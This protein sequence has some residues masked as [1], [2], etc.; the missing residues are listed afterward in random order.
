M[1][2]A[3]N[4]LDKENNNSIGIQ[5]TWDKKN[6][7]SGPPQQKVIYVYTILSFWL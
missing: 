4:E 5:E 6:K 7:S 2:K 1:P 3:D